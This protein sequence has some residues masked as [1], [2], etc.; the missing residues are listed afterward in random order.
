MDEAMKVDAKEVEE[1]FAFIR[2]RRAA[3][4]AGKHEFAC[5]LCGRPASWERSKPNGHVRA[6]CSGCGFKL[7]A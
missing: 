1:T 3:E 7:M 5:P 2:A 4:A 6:S